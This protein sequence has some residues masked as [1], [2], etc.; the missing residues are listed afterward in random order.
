MVPS[1]VDDEAP[2]LHSHEDARV[3]S[4]E[5]TEGMV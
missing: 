5:A 4:V 1:A 3:V 2:E